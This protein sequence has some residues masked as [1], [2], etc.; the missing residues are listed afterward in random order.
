MKKVYADKFG[1][2]LPLI[3]SESLIFSSN[4][5]TFYPNA[6][7]WCSGFDFTEFM[8]FGHGHCV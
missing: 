4:S 6:G 8:N 2:S 1:Y 3:D 7:H 5:N